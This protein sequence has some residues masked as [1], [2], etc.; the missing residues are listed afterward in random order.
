VL[1]ALSAAHEEH[2]GKREAHEGPRRSPRLAHAH[3]VIVRSRPTL[4]KNQPRKLR[5][6]AFFVRCLENQP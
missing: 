4:R 1:R 6:F 5:S 2:A 3:G